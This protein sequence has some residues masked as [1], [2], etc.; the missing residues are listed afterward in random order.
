M[1]SS[2]FAGLDEAFR[3]IE[4]FT[5]FEKA[6]PQSVRD[7]KLDRMVKLLELFGRP[8]QVLK[9]YHLAGS[10]G[11]GSTA[12]FLAS[13]L[14]EEGFVTGL[15][16]SPHVMT[17]RE[18]ITRAG[19]FFPDELILEQINRIHSLVGDG[20]ALKLAGEDEN[21]TTFELLTLL[22]F[23]VFREAGC[24]HGVIETGIGG[25]LDATNVI[26]PEACLL[27]PVELEH[28][29][30]LGKTLGR[31][32][33]EKAGIIK[34][35]VPVLSGHQQPEVRKLFETTAA[36]RGSPITFLEDH[37]GGV[38]TE[39]EGEAMR[40]DLR[41]RDGTGPGRVETVRLRMIG[42]FQAENAALAMLTVRRLGIAGEEA[43]IRGIGKARLPGRMEILGGEPPCIFDAAH[44][45]SSLKRLARAYTS[46]FS[47][48]AVG[49]FGCVEGKLIED[50]APVLAT[51]CS[52]LIVSTPGTFKKSNP[53]GVYN[54][55]SRVHPQ[56]S[57][58]PDPLRA[59]DRARSLAGGKKPI[60]VAGSFYMVYEIRK[61]FT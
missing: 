2:A 10:K 29:D 55:I 12:Q 27:T 54:I 22:G 5:N 46:C 30:I 57:F 33:F 52:D 31:I 13:I 43:V 4:S 16:T 25:R 41:W 28:T 8:E 36:E 48:P 44:T 9:L 20:R 51:F 35:G 39:L 47:V 32:A 14:A 7:F 24:T 40:A 42:D 45:P 19:E 50:M 34:P 49:I 26:S 38:E 21:P 15:Y 17:Y 53:E 23:C 18:R 37:L 61:L 11:K 56:V 1:G 60:V 59:F 3:Y 58:E 6:T